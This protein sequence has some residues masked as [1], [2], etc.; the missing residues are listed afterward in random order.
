M[1]IRFVKSGK[2]CLAGHVM[3]T[4]EASDSHRIVMRM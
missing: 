2:L 4:G 3:K 1:I